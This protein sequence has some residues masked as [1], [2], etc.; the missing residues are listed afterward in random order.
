MV[1]SVLYSLDGRRLEWL[2]FFGKFVNALVVSFFYD[3]KP[4]GVRRLTTTPNTHLTRI[5]AQFIW[6]RL[7]PLWTP[8]FFTMFAHGSSLANVRCHRGEAGCERM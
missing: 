7:I 6:R 3:G 8:F 5:V 4:F 1:C 2:P